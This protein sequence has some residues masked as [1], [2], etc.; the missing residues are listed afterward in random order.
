MRGPWDPFGSAAIPLTPSKLD[1]LTHYQHFHTRAAWPRLA[2]AVNDT[3]ADWPFQIKDAVADPLHLQTLFA[4]GAFAKLCVSTDSTAA[5]STFLS[6]KHKAITLLRQHI[7]AQSHDKATV[8]A[9]MQ[10]VSLSYHAGYYDE[11]VAYQRGANTILRSHSTEA[12]KPHEMVLVTDIWLS[13]GDMELGPFAPHEFDPGPWQHEGLA[14]DRF[15]YCR[16]P[17][18][19]PQVLPESSLQDI[20]GAINELS[21]VYDWMHVTR[22]ANEKSKVGL[23]LHLRSTAIKRRLM[24]YLI[25]ARRAS[26][27]PTELLRETLVTTVCNAAICYVNFAFAP[28]GETHSILRAGPLGAYRR[29]LRR[30]VVEAGLCESSRERHQPLLL[31]LLFVGIV[32]ERHFQQETSSPQDLL[33]FE[34]KFTGVVEESGCCSWKDSKSVLQRYLYRPQIMDETLQQLHKPGD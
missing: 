22:N 13:I 24:T 16:L 20:F 14:E 2:G 30:V 26:K 25:T 11:A 31:W 33:L 12:Y 28:K 8:L 17:E 23:W 3:S 19:A 32:S 1:L 15:R 6:T 34:S 5:L 27:K 29:I 10:M 18:L 9:I 7:T 4:C 21:E